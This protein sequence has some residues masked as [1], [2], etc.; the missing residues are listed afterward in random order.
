VDQ[1]ID[2][3]SISEKPTENVTAIPEQSIEKSLEK[4]P[5]KQIDTPPSEHSEK[6]VDTVITK[7]LEQHE[8]Q[9][10][11]PNEPLIDKIN[12]KPV[13]PVKPESS[14]TKVSFSE[15]PMEKVKSSETVLAK[16]VAKQPKP[17]VKTPEKH[18]EK[19]TTTTKATA[20]SIEKPIN[21]QPHK[22]LDQPKK[23]Q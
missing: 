1:Q 23:S 13:A 11:K 4:L 9:I 5:E 2:P 17:V 8:T 22:L 20:T 18:V 3:L 14:T 12:D 21:K 16:P 6:Q 19:L 7:S 15:V 10:E